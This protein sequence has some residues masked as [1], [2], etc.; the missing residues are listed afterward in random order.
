MR[1]PLM[2]KG[3]EHSGNSL[4]RGSMDTMREPLMP[5]GVEHRV[6]STATVTVWKCENL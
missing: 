5:K 6:P 2:P 1:E 3:V 4:M